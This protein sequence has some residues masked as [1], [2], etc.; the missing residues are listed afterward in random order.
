MPDLDGFGDRPWRVGRSVGRTVYDAHDRLI[1]VMDT[2]V[3]ASLVVL[4]VNALDDASPLPT[5]TLL[6]AWGGWWWRPLLG[7]ECM[8]GADTYPPGEPV[9][10]PGWRKVR[11]LAT[12]GSWREDDSAQ[13]G[14]GQVRRAP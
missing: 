13:S 5:R 14:A 7:N 4:G 2:P 9:S 3:L 12:E 8:T 10:G 11:P 6:R 1:G